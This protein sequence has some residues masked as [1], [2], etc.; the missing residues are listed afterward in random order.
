M[1]SFYPTSLTRRASRSTRAVLSSALLGLLLAP[2]LAWTQTRIMPLGDSHTHGTI[3]HNTYRRALWH[4]LQAGG[5]NV[6]FV[7]SEHE[8][9]GGPPPNPDFDPDHQG[10]AGWRTEQIRDYAEQ[11][12]RDAQPDIVLLH[13][14]TNDV[15]QRQSPESTRDELSQVIDRLRAA[16]PNV[17]ILLAQLIPL[18]TAPPTPNN[19]INLLNALL[20]ALARQ[21]STVLSPVVLVDINTGFNAATDLYDNIH[22]NQG[23]E[24]KMAAR[25]YAALQ[26]LLGA[27]VGQTPPVANAG[28][29]Q[30]LIMPFSLTNNTVLTGSGTD[31]DGTV[32]SYAWTQVSGPASVTFSRQTVASPTVS[33]FAGGTYEFSLVVTD[34]AGLSSAPDQVTVTI[35]ASP[36]PRYRL[37]AGGLAVT[38]ASGTF[39]A[40]QY[41]LGGNAADTSSP[42]A[43]TADDAL[44]QTE[45]WGSMSYNLPVANGTYTVKLHFAEI[46][47]SAPGQRVFDVTAEGTKMLSAYD[48]LKKVGPNTATIETFAV[49]VTDGQLTLAFAPG[50]AGA[51]EPKVSAIEVF[52]FNSTGNQPPVANAGAD[53]TLTLPTSST[54]LTGTGTDPDGNVASY[55]WTQMSG[56][57]TASFSNKAVAQPTLSGLVAGPYVF[58]LVVTDN[59]GAPSVADQVSVTVNAAPTGGVTAV[60]RLNAG[61]PA[62]TTS[63]LAFAADQYVSGGNEADSSNPIAG[64]TD[65]T[66]Y[67]T[68]RWGTMTYALPVANGTYTVKLH[69][70]EV[71][72]SAPGQ[73]VFDVTAEGTKVLSAYDIVRKAGPNTA[74]METFT[75]NVTDGQLTLAF[76]PGT[77]GADEPKVS[78]IEVLAA[79]ATG[80]Q[81]P[82]ANA[83][84]DQILMLPTS[85]TTLNGSGTDVDG[86]IA[87]Y[88]WTQVSGPNM[89]VFS[90]KTVATPTV[91]SL[92]AGT[93][94]FSLVVKDNTG[95]AS[96]ADQVTVIVNAPS[97]GGVTALYRLNAGGP[98]L[99]TSGLAFSADQQYVTGGFP[100][101]SG[102]AIAGTVDDVLY[103]TERWGSMSYNLPVSNGTYTVKLHFA[104]VYFS[105]PG[106][107]VFDVTAEGTKVLSAYD[108]V[109][110]AGPNTAVMETFTINVTD[111][112]LTLA[113]APGTSGE[114]EPKVS[115][116]EVLT[117]GATSSQARL[118]AAAAPALAPVE[119]E[120]QLFPNPTLDGRF[121]VLLA[122]GYT[123]E[124]TYTLLAATGAQVATGKRQLP[125]LTTTLAFDL[126]RELRQPGLY[127][128]LLEGK[129]LRAR[130]KVQRN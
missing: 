99:T 107:R 76:A 60:Y 67:Q 11:F 108:I 49:T 95:L 31:A 90:S 119:H 123:G 130:V 106:Q 2:T 118:L 46:Y 13:A 59:A 83:G 30:H 94:V 24:E 88:A 86:T 25:W 53:Q 40:D 114:D 113:F 84:A 14:G 38:T 61:G 39:A 35:N 127:Y 21:K 71:Y 28:P 79:S 36:A 102:A 1:P 115:A 52:T 65:D 63:G 96:A 121:H 68:E 56:P 55:A 33:G 109:R 98:A 45:R 41:A 58:S 70:A 92:M 19:D 10:Q 18:V 72:W 37:N 20:P 66:L 111:G 82:L 29:D 51:D 117:T 124:L 120:L 77:A 97:T 85:S 129:G 23:G 80:N 87:T 122:P 9:Y 64:T 8:N 73:R 125:S 62:L 4:Q 3:Y 116:I 6:D 54:R 22:L 93:Y 100:S 27:P 126:T 5:Y 42:I 75:I 12:A 34:N 74:V 17:K 7:G 57:N 104:E 91:S 44:Y 78:A 105:D 32:V 50:P 15:L 47:W 112:Q 128:L 81:T 103:Q 110:K 89:A 48:I 43:G 26:A 69:F 101:G 16:R